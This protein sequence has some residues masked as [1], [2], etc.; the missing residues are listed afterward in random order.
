M[1]TTMNQQRDPVWNGAWGWITR[2]HEERTLSAEAQ[3]ELDVWLAADERHRTAYAEATR[4]W[5]LAG[6]VPPVHDV[7][8]PGAV[9][10]DS[11]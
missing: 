2:Q 5:F 1:D 10:C 11:D 7:E 9:P 6:F 3:R 8:V 4:L